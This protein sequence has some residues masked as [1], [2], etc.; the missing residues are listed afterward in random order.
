MTTTSQA[1]DVIKARVVAASIAW[2]INWPGD[3][4]IQL[5]DT[6]SAFVSVVFDVDRA[7]FAGYGGGRGANLQRNEAWLTFLVYVPNGEGMTSATDKAEV[8]SALFR[9]YR[10]ANI[11]CFAAV[12]RPEGP[13]SS[14]RP[15][16]VDSAVDNY[17]VASAEI[18]LHFDLVG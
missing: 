15:P 9:S 1:I 17:Y 13:G 4:G 3:D 16:G 8:F 6:P 2:P 10:D 11:S 18:G 5:P 7:F 12:T 14:M